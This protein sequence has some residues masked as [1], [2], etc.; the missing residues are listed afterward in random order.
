M[1]LVNWFEF[2]NYIEAQE[3]AHRIGTYV[4]IIDGGG[5]SW[6]W[7][8][9]YVWPDTENPTR[10]V[11][12]NDPTLWISGV[13]K[14]WTTAATFQNNPFHYM[15]DQSEPLLTTEDQSHL[16]MIDFDEMVELVIPE[17]PPP[18]T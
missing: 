2:D 9:L 8:P 15:I 16:T 12:Q 14:V 3:L 1:T 7:G 5:P 11:V 10:F 13:S 6:V 4:H 17:P 18:E